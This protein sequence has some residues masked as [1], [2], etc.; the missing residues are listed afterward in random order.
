MKMIRIAEPGSAPAVLPVSA[1]IA[2][3]LMFGAAS[4][5]QFE[6]DEAQANENTEAGVESAD[7]IWNT[8]LTYGYSADPEATGSVRAKQV[9][10]QWCSICHADGVGM[11]GTDSLKRR[12]MMGRI[13]GIS[14]ILEERTDLTPE[15]V[16]YVVRN[17]IKSMPYFRKTEVSDSD[18]ELIAEYLAR[19]N[20]DYEAE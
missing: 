18:L 9:Y 17:G 11:A 4:A 8:D 20:P 6:G 12:F 15:Y 19:K 10:D 14:P 2:F 16:T 3:L 1:M 5:E 13:E 7:E